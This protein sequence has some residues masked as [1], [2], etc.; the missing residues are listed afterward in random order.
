M[1]PEVKEFVGKLMA[2]VDHHVT[3]PSY[4]VADDSTCNCGMNKLFLSVPAEL[5]EEDTVL[6][7]RSMMMPAFPCPE[8]GIS[9]IIDKIK[10]TV[11]GGTLTIEAGRVLK[12]HP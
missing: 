7:F 11:V 4:E 1:T 3:C 9:I 5:A 8:C 6:R 2:Y 12:E 10:Y